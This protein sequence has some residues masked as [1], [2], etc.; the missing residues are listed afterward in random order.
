MD[1][2]SKCGE[3]YSVHCPYCHAC[4]YGDD[5]CSNIYCI[6]T[7]IDWEEQTYEKHTKDRARST[8]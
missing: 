8:S 7:L 6:E 4:D 2:C 1:I 3:K 5:E